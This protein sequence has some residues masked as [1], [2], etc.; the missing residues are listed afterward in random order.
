LNKPLRILIADDNID[1]V[2]MLLAELRRCGIE[3]D[4]QRVETQEDYLCGLVPGLD[5]I[6]SD[7]SMP[8]FGG[9]LALEI[10]KET[11]LVIPFIVVSGTI[12]EDVAVDMMKK[13]AAD[14]LIKDRLGRLGQA[15]E[16]AMAQSRLRM[17]SQ[18]AQEAMCRTMADLV[19]AERKAEAARAEAERAN[20]A[21]SQFLANMSHEIR[22]PLNGIIGMTNLTLETHLDRDQREFLGM[23]KSSA[24]SLL[25]L[26]NDILDFSKIE[27]GKLELDSVDFS[28][29]H[30]IGGMLKP[31]AIRADQKGLKLVADISPDAPDNM[32]GDPLRL[33][34]ILINL[35]DNAIKFTESGEVIVKLIHQP[36]L[37]G[38]NHLHFAIS[39]TGIGIPAEKQSAIFHA[40]E[41]ADGSTTRTYGGTGLGLSIASQL[42]Q[43]MHGRIWIESKVGEGTTFHFTARL[44][45]GV[46]APAA[47]PAAPPE[48]QSELRDAVS[49][50]GDAQRERP[51]AKTEPARLS[52]R[53]LLA[54]DN[55]INRALAAGIL[56]KRGHSLVH[57]VDGREAV[58]AAARETFDLIFMDVQMPEMGG[59]EATR[60]IREAEL[61]TGRHT[62]IAAM[63]A[64]AMA[65]DRE[66]S[67]SAGMDDY[68]S[69]PLDKVAL[70]ALLD[71]VSAARF[72]TE[73][74]IS[75]P[76]LGAE[77]NTLYIRS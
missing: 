16:N 50:G 41:Q 28:L 64:H 54:E 42:I 74:R 63:T 38:Y 2:D 35:T 47:V 13:G 15:V 67:L 7:Y 29:R 48:T 77:L 37:K 61:A 3:P 56:E 40:F 76:S 73:R 18:H 31:L 27:A 46:A 68:L 59:F 25:G 52:L 20:A 11:G 55:V 23:V 14:F 5:I 39:D 34:Q 19:E 71:R 65:G 36:A 66:R 60:H 17:E 6:I 62:P 75:K 72:T 70:L 32:A 22:T 9:A 1:D 69:K 45:V 12:G 4:W 30:C 51:T 10:L 57:A 33:R 58:Q 49:I 44:G 8:L 43:K 21:K 24:Y 26:I 53:I